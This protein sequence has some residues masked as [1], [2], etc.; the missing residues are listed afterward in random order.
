MKDYGAQT[1]GDRI[2]GVYDELYGGLFDD[3]AAVARL[4][5]LA[6]DGR[7]LELAIGTGRIALPLQQ[8]GVDVT[9]IDISEAMVAQLRAK[10]GGTEIPI[11]IGDMGDVGVDGHFDLVF[12]VF[13]TLFALTSQ[14]DQ[15]RCFANVERHLTDD[16]VFVVEAFV[17]DS[18][19]FTR[20][21]TVGVDSLGTDRVY[22]EASRHDPVT[23]TVDSQH[24]VLKQGEPVEMF[25]VSIRYSYPTE[26]DLM[27]RLAGLRLRNRWG[28][29]REEP[30]TSESKFHVSVFERAAE[31]RTSK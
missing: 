19:R 27:A 3:D 18:T 4:A 14:E 21:Q 5:E 13:N 30:F 2:A 26:I 31:P 24:I 20:H 6:G 11:V 23:Q 7:A 29:W 15:V 10:P 1:Y 16:G 8:R 25:P 22:L 28:G 17:P 12:V 9:G